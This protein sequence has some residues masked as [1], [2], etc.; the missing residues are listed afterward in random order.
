M[1]EAGGENVGWSVLVAARVVRFSGTRAVSLHC[2]QTRARSPSTHRGWWADVAV[3]ESV[4]F[5][6][7]VVLHFRL[8]CVFS[9]VFIVKIEYLEYVAG[10]PNLENTRNLENL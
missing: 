3:Y 9:L 1:R 4:R 6:A 2:L 5:S 8:F 10:L 7:Q